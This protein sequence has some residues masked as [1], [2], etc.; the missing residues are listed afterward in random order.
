MCR[1]QSLTESSSL[2][3]TLVDVWSIALI[4][5]SLAIDLVWIL[6]TGYI[7]E[8]AFIT[9]RFAQQIAAGNGFVY[10]MG[11]PIYGTTTPLLTLLLA[12]WLKYISGDV[13][14]G[15]RLLNL[16]ASGGMLFFTWRTLRFLGRSASEQIFVLIAILMSSRL[17][18]MNT[19]GMEMPL[20]LC[21]MAASWYT[22]ATGKVGWTGFLCG[23]LLWT[24]V[25]LLFW[26]AILVIL[27]GFQS[28]KSSL[29][30]ALFAGLTYLP[31]VLFATM[32]FGSPIPFTVTAKWV[33]YSQFN[34]SPLTNHLTT[35]LEYLSPFRIL[36]NFR[37][38]GVAM[39]L[40]VISWATARTQIPRERMFIVLFT[41]IILEVTRLTF[42][43]ATFFSRYF[44]P[45]LWATLILFGVALSLL[46]DRLKSIRIPRYAIIFILVLSVLAA[47]GSGISF[48]Q[49]TEARQ[50]Y[51]YEQSLKPIGIWL[52]ENGEPQNTI[53]LE[54]LGYVGYYSGLTMIDE[55]GLV[56]PEVVELKRQRIQA[57][58]YISFFQP[59]YVILHCDDALR[60][61]ADE[62]TGLA[63]NY[64]L[65]Q[66]FNPL[67]FDPGKQLPPTD[68]NTL[69]RSSCYQIWQRVG[70]E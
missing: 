26:P 34:G 24:R 37:L 58:Q 42:T 27:A 36:G 60:L 5:L 59:D 30:L 48:A 41:F 51:R 14:L 64:E 3:L 11:Q 15:A 70:G 55:V 49:A 19:Q 40:A 53:L 44:V 31:W 21:L 6:Y 25:D 20:V 33:A 10:N 23:L 56:T 69:A 38:V 17:I 18:Y 57:E 22:F 67:E 28:L 50:T 16:L 61:H 32:Y 39:V 46:W 52:S 4:V 8:D 66:T 12:G 9:F 54:P 29:R 43:R 68:L 47:I 7:E 62:S 13:V 1:T 63:A 35:I 2:R 45:I 65:A